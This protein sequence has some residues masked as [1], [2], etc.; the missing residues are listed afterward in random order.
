[1]K[2]QSDLTF[3]RNPTSPLQGNANGADFGMLGNAL[4]ASS[5][6]FRAD[7]IGPL[8]SARWVLVWNP[9]TGASPTYVR[10]VKADDGP[11]NLI[12]LERFGRSNA[13]SPLVDAV[14]ITAKLN[15]IISGGIG[16]QLIEQTCGNGA[17]GPLIYAS[18]IEMVFEA[19]TDTSALQAQVNTLSSQ[20]ASLEAAVAALQT[21]PVTPNTVTVPAGGITI[22]F[23]QEEL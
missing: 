14:D 16:K 22:Q 1:M 2:I 21:A 23:V 6:P 18:W 15:D 20:I 19:T 12:E 8:V 5:I 17:N 10:L 7:Q 13:A 9:N 11:S 4:T 3:Y